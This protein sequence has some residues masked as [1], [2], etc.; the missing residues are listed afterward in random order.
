MGNLNFAPFARLCAGDF[1]GRVLE[2]GHTLLVVN[3]TFTS[4]KDI[5]Q[6]SAAACPAAAICRSCKASDALKR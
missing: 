6:A 5:G 3:P 4:S 2:P 1:G